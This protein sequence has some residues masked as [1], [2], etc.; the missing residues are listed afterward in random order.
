MI[1]CD[2]KVMP[3]RAHVGHLPHSRPVTAELAPQLSTPASPT[4]TPSPH[5]GQSQPR[6]RYLHHLISPLKPRQVLL[7][8]RTIKSETFA[9]APRLSLQGLRTPS[10]RCWHP[11]HMPASRHFSVQAPTCNLS[12]PESCAHP[13]T[14]THPSL[15]QSFKSRLPHTFLNKCC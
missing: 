6:K 7:V 15:C 8:S 14:P 5:S 2:R 10:P 3:A 4:C 12:R 1:G 11:S 9:M 13:S